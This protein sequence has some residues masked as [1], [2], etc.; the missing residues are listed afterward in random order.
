MSSP[1][2]EQAARP[3]QAGD[4]TGFLSPAAP[5]RGNWPAVLISTAV[6][7]ALYGVLFARNRRFFFIDDRVADTLP[8]LFDIGRA[9][10]AG[11]WPWLTTAAVNSGAHAIEYQNGVFNPLMLGLSVPLS[12]TDDLAVGAFM[13]VLVHALLLA[14]ASAWLGRVLGL[15][16]AW[17]VAFAVSIGFQ[18]YTVFWGAAAWLQAVAS[19]AWFVLAVAAALAFHQNPRHRY[20][21][22]L[23]VAVYGCFTSGWPLAVPVLGLFVLT[24]LVLRTLARVDLRTTLW[25][26][27]WS[28]GGAVSSLLA[29]YPLTRA[30]EFADR[31]SSISNDSN[32]NVVPI[33]GLLQFANPAYYGFLNSFGGYGLQ[34]I[35]H[36]Y[37]AWFVLPVLVFWQAGR[38]APRAALL[39]RIAASMLV[40]VGVGALGP[41]RLGVFR[42]PTRFL[43]YWAFFLLVVTVV[44]VAS[45]RFSFTRRRLR[46]LLGALVLMALGALQ[47]DPTGT[48]RV[49]LFAVGV[50]ALSVLLYAGGRTAAGGGTSWLGRSGGPVAAAGTAAVLLALALLHPDGRGVDY[51]FPTDLST[52]PVLSQ[53]DY[54]LFY[55]TYVSD[56]IDDAQGF[57]EE[58]RPAGTGLM[59]GDR[60]IN[61]YSPIGHSAFRER[62]PM[63]DQGNFDHGDARFTARDPLTGLQFLELFRVDQII[64]LKGPWTDD[65]R[66]NLGEGW[67][68]QPRRR[69][70]TVWRHEPYALPGLVSYAAPGTTVSPGTSPG[71]EATGALRECNRV[72]TPPDRRGRVVF[73]RLWFPGYTATLDGEPLPVL[74]HAGMLVSVVV[75]PGSDGELVLTYRSPHV[76]KLALLAGLVVVGLAVASVP[77]PGRL[78]RRRQQTS[79]PPAQ[80]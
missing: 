2:L 65:L 63:D 80:G 62:F 45:G 1:A 18:P 14:G 56:Q 60:Q 52:L 46:W 76:R 31:T 38:L 36:F 48:A 15:G 13:L 20:G 17:S 21:W 33:D 4:A 16:Q 68:R 69:Y 61:G 27:A 22:T 58:Y 8:K 39:L 30:F 34:E 41:E 9:L 23:L 72:R 64:A 79:G 24:V 6:T 51:R 19:F 77:W 54:T 29:L 43:Q 78:L 32:F 50:A 59:V 67:E 40:F 71:C 28:G 53:D 57:Y 10:R 55:G 5:G 25:I 75:P 47:A 11:E 26:A 70:T 42:Y 49:L 37:T 7:A 12:R 74:R 35:P 3:V 73:A 66:R 44:L